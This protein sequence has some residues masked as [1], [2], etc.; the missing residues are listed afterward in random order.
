MRRREFLIGGAAAAWP[1]M[2]HAQRG[3]IPVIGF[4]SSQSP[5]TYAPFAAAFRRGLGESGFLEDKNITIENRWARGHVNQLPALAAEL[6][7]L[8]VDVIA[9][10]GGVATA[11]A[12]KAATFSIPIV[13]N[14]GEDPVQAGIVS[15][16]NRPGGLLF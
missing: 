15:S 6:V 1:V 8:R 11:L 2:A 14:S 13:F 16:I 3:N 12:A 10:T 4:L 7:R 5:D 9:A